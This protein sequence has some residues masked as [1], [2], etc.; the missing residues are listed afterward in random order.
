ME[1]MMLVLRGY[2]SKDLDAIHALDVQ[3]FEQ[4]FRFSRPAMQKFAEAKK[5]RVVVAES[6]GALAGFGILH[7]ESY[8]EGS[9]GYIV[10]LDVALDQR[11]EGVGKSLIQEMEK[12]SLAAGCDVFAL[13][14]YTQNVTAIG[15]YERLGF[16]YSHTAAGFYGEGLDAAVYQ[17]ELAAAMGSNSK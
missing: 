15:F 17:K 7:I 1:T 12:Q 9:V 3:C 16:V 10:T 13:H 14:V 6:D 5:A 11:R 2:E 4:P 8:P